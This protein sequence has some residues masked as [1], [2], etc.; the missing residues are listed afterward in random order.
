MHLELE[1]VEPF[2]EAKLG[3]PLLHDLFMDAENVLRDRMPI[4]C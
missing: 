3:C 1:M 4:I 2:N